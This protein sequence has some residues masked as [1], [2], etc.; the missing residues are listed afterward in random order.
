MAC[1][2]A[3]DLLKVKY[4]PATYHIYQDWAGAQKVQ[5]EGGSVQKPNLIWYLVIKGLL[6]ETLSSEGSISADRNL[7]Y[8]ELEGTGRNEYSLT[9]CVHSACLETHLFENFWRLWSPSISPLVINQGDLLYTVC[10]R[11][12]R[13]SQQ[14]R[15]IIFT[16]WKK[17]TLNVSAKTGLEATG[18]Q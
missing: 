15:H 16:G 1:V 5:G 8:R 11:P 6:G 2:T 18:I 13:C 10:F 4:S 12:F 3:K 17:I 7:I 14:R 9:C